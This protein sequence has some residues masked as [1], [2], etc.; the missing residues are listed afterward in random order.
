MPLASIELEPLHKFQ[1]ANKSSS[2]RL[3]QLLL[4]LLLLLQLFSAESLH[5]FTR[6]RPQYKVPEKFKKLALNWAS[7][8]L[9][10]GQKLAESLSLGPLNTANLHEKS[11]L[12]IQKQ[13]QNQKR[14]LLW[15]KRQ[16][17][18]PLIINSLSYPLELVQSGAMY[19]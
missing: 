12:Q 14:A 6:T 15:S 10:S 3:L 19:N 18:L 17:S 4:Q 11:Q 9:F 1:R 5:E 16:L 13:C 7:F 8:F 2:S